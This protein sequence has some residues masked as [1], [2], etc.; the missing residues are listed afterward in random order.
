MN[1]I[2]SNKKWIFY[3]VKT[4]KIVLKKYYQPFFV[5][6]CPQMFYINASIQGDVYLKE[7]IYLKKSLKWEVSEETFKRM[8]DCL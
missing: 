3:N 8:A 4:K 1:F 5:S 7:K 6:F 2:T